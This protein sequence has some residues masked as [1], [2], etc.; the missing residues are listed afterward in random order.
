MRLL[1]EMKND[2]KNIIKQHEIYL[3]ILKG[4]KIDGIDE[5][6]TTHIK[7]PSKDWSNLTENDEIMKYFKK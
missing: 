4:R 1:A 3:D 6:V 2:K 5:I 7:D